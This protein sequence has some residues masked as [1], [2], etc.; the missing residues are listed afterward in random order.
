MNES[1][2]FFFFFPPLYSGQQDPRAGELMY[3]GLA[4]KEH[5]HNISAVFIHDVRLATHVPIVDPKLGI[6][7]TP[8]TSEA[9]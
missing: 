6:K 4:K 2:Y 5:H 1:L 8:K 3:E 9:K 7:D